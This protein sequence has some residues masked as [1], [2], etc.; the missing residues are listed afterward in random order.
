MPVDLYVGGAEHAVLHLLYARFWHKVLFDLGHVST[1]EPFQRLVNQGTITG[2]TEFH[3]FAAPNGVP[4]SAADLENIEEAALPEGPR[5]VG[6]KKGSTDQFVGSPISADLVEKK[7]DRYVLKSNPTIIVDAR[8]FKMSKSRGN[9]IN[10]DQ[11][12]GDYGAD[13]FRLYEMY[14]GPLEA[15]KPWNTRD[16]VGMSRFLSAVYRNLL[17]DEEANKPAAITTEPIN[18]EPRSPTPPHHQ[19]SRRRHHRPALQ[20]RNRRTDQT[21]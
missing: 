4:V 1:A 15:P 17:G 8:S 2:E 12:V 9:V 20:H 5:L 6:T 10:P 11:L 3:A 14:M 18:P 21:Q 13:T 16:I 19:K 7:G